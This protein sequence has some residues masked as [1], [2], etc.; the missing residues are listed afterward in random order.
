MRDNTVKSGRR[1]EY[2]ALWQAN[3]PQVQL[4]RPKQKSVLLIPKNAVRPAAVAVQQSLRSK[5]EESGQTEPAKMQLLDSAKKCPD[6]STCRQS[7]EK[8]SE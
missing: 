6:G 2:E 7:L 1:S 5:Q 3:P 4:L 8:V